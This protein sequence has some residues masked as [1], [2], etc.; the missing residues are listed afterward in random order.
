MTEEEREAKL[1]RLLML[2]LISERETIPVASILL[3]DQEYDTDEPDLFYASRSTKEEFPWLANK[4]FTL[5]QIE[6]L[7]DEF[8]I[9]C[10]ALPFREELI[11]YE[12][13]IN[14]ELIR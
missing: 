1:H 10:F 3:F 11:D 9:F 2:K 4:P 12:P 5:A 14:P 6:Q 7:M 8:T 13:D